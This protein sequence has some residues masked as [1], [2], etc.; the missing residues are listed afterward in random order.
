MGEAVC[1]T[2]EDT[3]LG[4]DFEPRDDMNRDTHQK[5]RHYDSPGDPSGR[6]R[7]KVYS[8]RTARHPSG[9]GFIHSHDF[10]RSAFASQ[11]WR[12]RLHFAR[13]LTPWKNPDHVSEYA[14]GRSRTNEAKEARPRNSKTGK[15]D[16]SR[17]PEPNNG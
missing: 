17:F 15:E 9:D 7:R 8:D 6:W 16:S 1:L 12:L 13:Q 11:P 2:C 14:R 4:F 10:A 3:L 5:R